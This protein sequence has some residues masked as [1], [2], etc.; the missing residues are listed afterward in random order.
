MV[1]KPRGEGMSAPPPPPPPPP[2]HQASL[3]FMGPI[4][5]GK[6]FA[7]EVIPFR[8]ILVS[9]FVLLLLCVQN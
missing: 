3:F 8:E 7:F 4:C 1:I 9:L 2:P 5:K 6:G